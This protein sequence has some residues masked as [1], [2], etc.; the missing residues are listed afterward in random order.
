MAFFLGAQSSFLFLYHCLAIAPAF[1]RP[2]GQGRNPRFTCSCA[3]YR[4]SVSTLCALPDIWRVRLADEFK[5]QMVLDH[6]GVYI[7]AGRPQLYVAAR[8]HRHCA[9]SCGYLQDV[10]TVEHYHIMGKWML[11]SPF[12]AYIASANTCSSVCE[13]AEETQYYLVRNTESVVVEL[14]LVVAVF[15]PL[16]HFAF[17]FHQ[18]TSA[19][20]CMVR[21]VL[22]MQMLMY[23]IIFR[24]CMHRV[25]PEHLGFC[26]AVSIARPSLHYLR[27]L[28]RLPSS[29]A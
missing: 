23:V 27:I 26:S 17:A 25:V 9:A 28:A 2:P 7:F 6:V 3:R 4:S 21:L 13:H 1:F 5:L 19:S 12:L 18:T 15:R 22:C 10:V 24:R 29:G 8:P 14:L 11:P 20:A 16:R